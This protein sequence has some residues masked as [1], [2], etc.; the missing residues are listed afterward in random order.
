MRDDELRLALFDCDG[1]LIDSQHTIIASM[2]AAFAAVGLVAP[3]DEKVRR[4]V[5]L[6]L[7]LAIAELA[8]GLETDAV[9]TAVDAYLA[10]FHDFHGDPDHVEPLYDGMAAALDALQVDGW[11]LGIAT[12]KSQRGLLSA[13]DRHGLRQRF[14]TLQTADVAASKPSPDMVHRA[15]A[16]T[17]V[18]RDRVVVIG[19]TGYDIAM[20]ANAGVASIGIGW[21][22]HSLAEL[23]AA[24]ATR[25][26]NACAE[27]PALLNELVPA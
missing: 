19:D 20:A 14:A 11:L 12:G 15:L 7:D 10:A 24:G 9:E 18:V 27:L 6:K 13:L 22:Y 25:T 1:T 8:V 5:G 26:A 3:P 2:A 17:R 4:V 23:S 16:E 21:G